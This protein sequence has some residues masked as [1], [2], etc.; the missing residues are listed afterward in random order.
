[1][2]IEEYL[3]FVASVLEI[4]KKKIN[5]DTEQNEVESWDSLM[6]LRLIGEIEEKY[7]VEIPLEEVSQIKSVKDF[8][9]YIEK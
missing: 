1:M 6:Q 3:E 4:D 8:W 5:M 9:K 2:R 7:H